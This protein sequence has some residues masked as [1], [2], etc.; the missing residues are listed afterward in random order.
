MFLEFAVSPYCTVSQTVM[1]RVTSP[2]RAVIVTGYI[3]FGVVVLVLTVNVTVPDRVKEGC[4]Q[5][6]FAPG[7][8]LTP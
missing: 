6:R 2:L 4:D 1:F 7:I 8:K 5:F 3:P